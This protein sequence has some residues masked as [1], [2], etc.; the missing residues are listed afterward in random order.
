[1]GLAALRFLRQ[2]RSED[3]LVLLG[4]CGAWLPWIL[5]KRVA[6]IQYLLPAVPMG[7]LAIAL[8]LERIRTR[9]ASVIVPAGYAVACVAM[10]VWFYPVWSAWPVSNAAYYSHRWFWFPGWR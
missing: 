6:F 8:S 9:V 7:I 5:V 3:G 1:L 4:F 2:R 10:F